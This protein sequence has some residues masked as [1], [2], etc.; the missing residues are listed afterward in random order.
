MVLLL[1]PSPIN[2]QTNK[3]K[4]KKHLENPLANLQNQ[5]VLLLD[6]SSVPF[7]QTADGPRKSMDELKMSVA[8]AEGGQVGECISERRPDESCS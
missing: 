5:H 6:C 7:R 1:R 8:V 3:K 2:K 4:K